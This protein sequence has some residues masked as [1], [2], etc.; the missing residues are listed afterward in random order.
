MRFRKQ[1]D[2]A[3]RRFIM[4][5]IATIAPTCA[6]NMH[7][8]D[9]SWPDDVKDAL[10]RQHLLKIALVDRLFVVNVGGY[11]GESTKKEIDEA[12]RLGLS[13]EYLEQPA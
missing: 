7:E 5:G 1:M 4:A 12:K 9:L 8:A 11:V 6:F 10:N 2:E 3:E 13:I